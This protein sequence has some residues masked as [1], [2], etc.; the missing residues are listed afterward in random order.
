MIAVVK[1]GLYRQVLIKKGVQ[2]DA[3]QR[4]PDFG[5]LILCDGSDPE[6]RRFQICNR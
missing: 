1:T 6:G 5:D 4:F 3:L 2:M